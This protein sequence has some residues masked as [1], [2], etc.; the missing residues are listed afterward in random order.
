MCWRESLDRKEFKAFHSKHVSVCHKCQAS[1]SGESDSQV[2]LAAQGKSELT[3]ST[4]DQYSERLTLNDAIY[5]TDLLKT[6][7]IGI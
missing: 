5:R 7:S 3:R 2:V 4:E 6:D 1:L